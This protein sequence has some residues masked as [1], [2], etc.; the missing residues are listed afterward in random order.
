MLR[1]SGSYLGLRAEAWGAVFLASNTAGA[2][3]IEVGG[4]AWTLL[5]AQVFG[6]PVPIP[7]HPSS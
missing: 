1:P 5:P 7:A 2:K 4:R 6:G 3:L